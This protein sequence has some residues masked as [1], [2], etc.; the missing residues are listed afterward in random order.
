MDGRLQCG[1]P[2]E[3]LAI[4]SRERVVNGASES[5]APEPGSPVG[6]GVFFPLQYSPNFDAIGPPVAPGKGGPSAVSCRATHQPLGS[7]SS[8]L[9]N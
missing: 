4:F 8:G 5:G 2:E 3:A 7:V 6:G 9:Y 1:G